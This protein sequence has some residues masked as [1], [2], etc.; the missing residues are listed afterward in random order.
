MCYEMIFTGT[1][2]VINLMNSYYSTVSSQ[3]RRFNS[4]V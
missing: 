4:I 2:V 1:K 3:I